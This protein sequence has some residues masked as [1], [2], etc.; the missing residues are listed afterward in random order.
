MNAAMMNFHS[1]ACQKHGL[2]SPVFSD[3]VSGRQPPVAIQQSLGIVWLP[4][5]CLDIYVHF[6][7]AQKCLDPPVL[8]N[9]RCHSM[10]MLKKQF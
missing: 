1:T 3:Q 9:D 4:A 2:V 8:S 10:V 5:M 6:S 7:T